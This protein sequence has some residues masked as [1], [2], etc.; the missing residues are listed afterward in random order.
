[1]QGRLGYRNAGLCAGNQRDRATRS[2][3]AYPCPLYVADCFPSQAR[4]IVN[5]LRDSFVDS[6]E[7]ADTRSDRLQLSQPTVSRRRRCPRLGFEQ[8]AILANVRCIDAVSFVAPQLGP[9]KV[10]NLG[11]IDDADN[12]TRVVQCA[13]D[14]QTIESSRFQTGMNTSHL[15]RDKPIQEMAP[16]I[17]GIR[18][19]L[20]V[21]LVVARQTRVECIFGNVDTQFTVGHC[22]LPYLAPSARAPLRATLYAGS[23]HERVPGYRP[24]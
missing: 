23:T 20:C 21:R 6:A 12:M 1:M 7:L 24:I 10:P 13:C 15:P 3:R 16:S 4:I 2:G 18:E 14:T 9:R 17:R 19:A 11:G 8:F 5:C 22:S